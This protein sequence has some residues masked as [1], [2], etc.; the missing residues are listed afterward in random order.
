M[1]GINPK[2]A[3]NTFKAQFPKTATVWYIRG[4]G[5]NTTAKPLKTE[6][7]LNLK[8]PKKARQNGSAKLNHV[9]TFYN[10]SKNIFTEIKLG[11]GQVGDF[12]QI[13]RGSLWKWWNCSVS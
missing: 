8:N 10:K 5:Q 7:T 9:G 1:C 12:K 11:V 2:I 6:L 13:R 4:A 3:S